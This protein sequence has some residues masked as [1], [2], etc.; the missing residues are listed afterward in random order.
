ML[1]FLK[2]NWFTI[3]IISLL[4]FYIGYLAITK[5]WKKIE[6][7]AYKIMLAAEKAV[8]TAD[9]QAKFNFVMDTAYRM[10]PRW[11]QFF[12]SEE[13]LKEKLQNWYNNMLDDLQN[14]ITSSP[15]TVL[16]ASAAA[17]SIP[18]SIDAPIIDTQETETQT[19]VEVSQTNAE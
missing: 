1:Y 5:Q 17:P 11:F 4:L 8:S 2:A 9:G 10:L 18:V 16:L 3:A 15:V 12:I 6:S 14:K 19:N 7:I 13:T